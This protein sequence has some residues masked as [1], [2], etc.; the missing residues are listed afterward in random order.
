MLRIRVDFKDILISFFA[1]PSLIRNTKP[2]GT[3]L[4]VVLL[5]CSGS[6]RVQA[7]STWS[8]LKTA[9]ETTNA[10]PIGITGDLTATSTISINRTVT[11]NGNGNEIKNGAGF[12]VIV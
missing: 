4:F 11:I 7:V 10:S 5:V 3:I 9:I 6:I 2:F 12:F 8:E 1:V